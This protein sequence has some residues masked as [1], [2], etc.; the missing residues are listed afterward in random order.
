MKKTI[1]NLSL[2]LVSF[3]LIL[4][5][6]GEDPKPEPTIDFTATVVGKVVT[7]TSTATDVTTYAWT[8]GDGDVSIEASPEHTYAIGGDYEVTCDVIGEG[9][10]ATVTKTVSVEMTDT[11]LLAGADG[12]TWKLDAGTDGYAIEI[13]DLEQDGAIDT[14]DLPALFLFGVLMEEEYN[15]VVTFNPDGSVTVDNDNGKTFGSITS[16]MALL[17]LA[18]EEAFMGAVGAGTVKLPMVDE[19]DDDVPET[20]TTEFGVCSFDY[21]V[22]A[23][24]W[25]FSTDDIVVNDE[26]DAMGLNRTYSGENHIKFSTGSYAGLLNV[27]QPEARIKSLTN[28]RLI[29]TYFL[30]VPVDLGAGP[31]VPTV[32]TVE[33]NLIPIAK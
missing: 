5:S 30:D 20:P 24:T 17:G 4:S 14:T 15:D 23:G 1:F 18:D 21:T 2:L 22:P 6:C 11:D 25:E 16:A 13:F 32:Y 19:D 10:T 33:L 3:A 27:G 31:M 12:K 28:D 8:F 26:L 29:L 7:F 9:G